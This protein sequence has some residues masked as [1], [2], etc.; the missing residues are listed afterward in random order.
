MW[1]LRSLQSIGSIFQGGSS[2]R[3]AVNPGSPRHS[4]R[5]SLWRHLPFLLG[6]WFGE[7]FEETVKLPCSVCELAVDIVFNVADAAIAGGDVVKRLCVSAVDEGKSRGSF[8][9][10]GFCLKLRELGC[11]ASDTA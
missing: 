11:Y 3:P 9:D 2:G 7:C 4:A 6:N 5:S 1:H 8:F 10:I